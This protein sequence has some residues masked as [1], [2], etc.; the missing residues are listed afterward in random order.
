MDKK[1][2]ENLSVSELKKLNE[3]INVE[4]EYK[5]A[6][7]TLS[8]ANLKGLAL[9]WIITGVAISLFRHFGR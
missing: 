8:N 5:R 4:I 9:V 3:S 6:L 1:N 7:Q 2:L